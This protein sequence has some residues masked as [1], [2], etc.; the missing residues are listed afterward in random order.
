MAITPNQLAHDKM[1]TLWEQAAETTGMNMTLSKDLQT[2]TMSD[3]VNKDRAGDAN[4]INYDSGNSDREYIPQEYR[5]EVKDGI[6][7]SDNDFQ[8]VIDRMVPVNRNKTFNV[9]AS[10]KA[11]ELQDPSRMT[12][13]AEGFARDIANKMDVMCYRTM[14][15][16][17]TL[18]I[19]SGNKFSYEAAIDA[20]TLLLNRGLSAYDRKLFLA[21]KHYSVVAKDLGQ[22]SREIYVGDAITRA[23]IPNLATFS[24]LRS[25][26]LLSNKGITTANLTVTNNSKHE[27][28]TYDGNGFYLDNRSMTLAVTNATTST[29]PVGCKFTITGV[30]AVHPETREDTGDLMTFT[31]VQSGSGSVVIQ[32]A[33]VADGVFKNCTAQAAAA[34]KIVLLNKIDETP[35]LFYTPQSTV[36]IPGRIPVIGDGVRTATLTTENGIPMTMVYWYDPHN[37]RYNMKAV[38]SF[39]VQVIYPEM[40]G[41]IYRTAT[42]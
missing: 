42:A 30:N 6:I 31:V 38:V 25:D 23:Q 4:D 13:I 7:T 15:D 3:M 11:K 41:A 33:L 10:I 39:D 28:T 5:F 37:M 20:E 8:N 24:T 14:I 40:L 34:A 9:P 22:Q 32:P 12:K 26:Y 35:S 17:S 2:Y 18:F 21:N 19:D 36:I 29:M 1:C 27:P 16:Q